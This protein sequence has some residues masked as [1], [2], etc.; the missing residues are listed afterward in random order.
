MRKLKIGDRVRV[1]NAPCCTPLSAIGEVFTIKAD[2]GDPEFGLDVPGATGTRDLWWYDEQDLELV[3]DHKCA[4]ILTEKVVV[5][6]TPCRKILGFEGILGRDE[7]PEKYLEGTPRF[8]FT[9]ECNESRFIFNG[10]KIEYVLCA[11]K[12]DCGMVDPMSPTGSG[13]FS[14]WDPYGVAVKPGD[15]L[16]ESAFQELLTWLRRAGS[17]LAKIREQEKAAWSGKETIEI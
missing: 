16:P 3:T 11:G 17:R 2:G 7:L 1:I 9:P 5:K 4:R 13:A 6:G 14:A 15:V 8:T 12:R 10:A